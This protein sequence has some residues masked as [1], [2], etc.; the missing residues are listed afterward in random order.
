MIALR[1]G[2]SKISHEHY[3]D[4]I[5]EVQ[6]K[7]KGKLSQSS[8]EPSPA[9]AYLVFPCR[10]CKL[11]RVIAKLH[12]TE[13]GK[14]FCTPRDRNTEL[15][16]KSAK[17]HVNPRILLYNCIHNEFKCILHPLP[18]QQDILCLENSCKA[19]Q[20]DGHVI[21]RTLSRKT[22]R[23]SHQ[24]LPQTELLIL[25]FPKVQSPGGLRSPKLARS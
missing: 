6:A 25:T 16:V 2:Q 11:L 8:P 7:K 21:C 22:Y 17:G 18:R 19:G 3:V 10:H 14:R 24:Q 9:D 5:S 15:L 1:S 4:A 13:P 12:A 20:M 23:V